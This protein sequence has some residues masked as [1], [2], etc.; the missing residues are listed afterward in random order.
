MTEFDEITPPE[1]VEQAKPDPPAYMRWLPFTL[2]V[3]GFVFD[4]VTLGRSV[5][6]INLAVVGLYASAVMLGLLIKSRPLSPRFR[7]GVQLAVHF[8]LGSLFSALVV[9]Y[10]RS[11]GTFFSLIIVMALFAAMVWNEFAHREESQL[12]LIWAIFCVSLVMYF[13]FLIPHI[14]GSISPWWFYISTALA[15]AAVWGLRAL[16]SQPFKTIRL[17]HG[18]AALIVAFY[19]MGW[20]PPV[21]LVMENSLVG[22]EFEREDGEYTAKVYELRVRDWLRPGPRVVERREGEPVY[23]LSAVSAPNR[24]EVMLEHRWYRRVDGKWTR[25]DTIPISIRGGREAGWRFYSFKRNLS[26]GEWKV[27]TALVDGAVLGYE[28][29]YLRDVA[30]DAERRHSRQA[31]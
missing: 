23:V 24:A 15:L 31:L 3:G 7:R 13:N 18:G 28:R 20:V 2:F 11:A 1:V 6:A 25:T 5:S 8:C 29:F 19:L 22:V 21:P 14:A 4:L 12:E 10:F 26:Q 27:E 17:A 30:V 16:A 9:L